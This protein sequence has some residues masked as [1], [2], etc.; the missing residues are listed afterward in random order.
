MHADLVQSPLTLGLGLWFG[1]VADRSDSIW[2]AIAAHIT[3]NALAMVG[4]TARWP[5]P[6]N[7]T[8]AAAVI[9]LA[10]AAADIRRLRRFQGAFM[11]RAPGRTSR[12]PCSPR[13]RGHSAREG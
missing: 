8:S 11:A 13:H 3:N 7:V 2:P 10:L 1:Y 12:W 4:A 9:V 6:L 5:L